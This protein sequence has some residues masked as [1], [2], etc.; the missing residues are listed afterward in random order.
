MRLEELELTRATLSSGLTAVVVRVPGLHRA[1]LNAH[2]RTGPA[3][4]RDED[5]GLS[6][7][8][9]HMLYRGTP[10]L[11]SAHAQA[12]AFESLGG[13]LAATTYVDHGAMALAVPPRVV[14]QALPLFADVFQHP[15][16]GGLEIEKGIVRQE[17]LEG[18]D[19]DEE[20]VDSD[21]LVRGLCFGQSGFGRPIV[22]T[23][24]HL[25]GFDRSALE[26]H[27]D[28]L[29]VG[30]NAVLCIAGS[31]D[32]ERVLRQV[33]DLFAALPPG[34]RPDSQP[35]P[36]QDGPRFRYVEN[37]G[38]QTELRVAFRAP[39][40]LDPLEPATDLLL[41][42][43]DDGMSTRL[44]HRIC[45]ELGLCY[46][47]SAG[48]EA[49]VKGGIFDLAAE[50]AHERALEVLQELLQ[51]TRELAADGPTESELDKIKARLVWHFDSMLDDPVELGS[52]LAS[53]IL[54]NV[55]PTAAFR[56]DQL[57]AVTRDQ[58]REAAARIFSP[59]HMSVVAVGGAKRKLRK[60]LRDSV[61]SL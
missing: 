19:E 59:T 58:T 21:E 1:V 33:E 34:A 49:Y 30:R 45:D 52:F 6:H 41:R 39:A 12:D 24:E 50:T 60:Q 53:G 56:R 37:P 32:P 17:M 7:F 44:Y 3:F 4:E 20:L 2:L 16:F 27:H 55:A 9:E 51:L 61:L 22:G 8:L 26:R 43:L 18:L 13:S 47:V 54:S 29:Y 48:Y 25:D 57:L 38:S 46:D 28:T 40:E 11:P 15:L 5:A 42:V 14:D 31:V 36:D 35:I 10:S 23:L